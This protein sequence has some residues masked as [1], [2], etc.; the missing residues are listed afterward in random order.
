[1]RIR[2]NR[3]M[4]PPL[5]PPRPKPP[6]YGFSMERWR[7]LEERIEHV[8]RRII[9]PVRRRLG[10]QVEY[11]TEPVRLWYRGEVLSGNPVTADMLIATSEGRVRREAARAVRAE[12][13]RAITANR[14]MSALG[15]IQMT[16][17]R[18]A[19]IDMEMPGFPG[20]RLLRWIR[21]RFPILKLIVLG[22]PRPENIKT[23][24]QMGCFSYLYKPVDMAKLITCIRN[25]L[26][27]RREICPV[28][29]FGTPCDRSC[30]PEG[31]DLQRFGRELK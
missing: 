14:P 13:F 1:M 18:G 9:E 28:E 15:H 22:P 19:V 30:V 29:R 4:F 23:A 25:V 20:W 16:K 17:F 2:D 10:I 6:Y 31:T 8:R 21:R 5:R 24:I 7:E 11:H 27:T 3:D 12:G 26:Y